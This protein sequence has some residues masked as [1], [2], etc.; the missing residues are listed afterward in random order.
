MADPASPRVSVIM[1][2]YNDLRF[3]DAAVQSILDQDYP[4]FELIIVDDGSGYGDSFA[5]QADRDPRV[6]ILTN[7]TNQG[8]MAASN[9][10]IGAARGEII[11]PLDADDLARP[12]R[13]RRLV[14]AL[15]ADP[16]LAIVG[17]NFINI[18]EAGNPGTLNHMPETDIDVR[19]T[20]LFRNPFCHSSV[21][22]RRVCYRTAGGY[23]ESWRSSSGDHEFWFRLLAQG[24]AGNLQQVLLE[25]RINPRGLSATYLPDWRKRTDPLR[26]RTWATLG[27]PYD[28]A[29][30]YELSHFVL[31]YEVDPSLRAPAYRLCLSLLRR[32]VGAPRPF[33]RPGDGADARRLVSKT[34]ERITADPAINARQAVDADDLAWAQSFVASPATG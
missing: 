19:W 28:P 3:F 4:D 17:S 6:R 18:D 22:F 13:L 20:I 15:D 25:Y 16:Q 31:G 5:R 2:A 1:P 27:I 30:A 12:E 33:A 29:L 8:A 23:D 34:M 21:A 10:G 11:A 24:R 26:E 7:S 32:F 14:A 9:R